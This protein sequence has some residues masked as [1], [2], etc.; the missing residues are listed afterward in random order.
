MKIN[1]NFS[2]P[3][4]NSSYPNNYGQSSYDQTEESSNLV[5]AKPTS[6]YNGDKSN[7][8]IAQESVV[9]VSKVAAV[10]ITESSTT[11]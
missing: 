6:E 4:S 7:K 11:N 2:F 3:S 1:L 10:P 5:S 8:V 9:T